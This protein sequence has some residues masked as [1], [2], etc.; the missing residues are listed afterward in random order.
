MIWDVRRCRDVIPLFRGKILIGPGLRGVRGDRA[1]AV[2]CDDHVR[3]VVRINPQIVEIAVRAVVHARHRL[4]AVGRAIGG[5]VLHVNHVH[6]LRVGK[7]VCVVERTLA[8][9]AIGIGQLPGFC[10]IV[11][12][13]ESAIL[14][15]DE[16]I[17]PIRVYRRHRHPD[18]ADHPRWHARRARDLG[19]RLTSVGGLEQSR[20][21]TTRRHGVF[22][23]ERFPHRRV[24]HVRIGAVNR[25]VNRGGLVVA[26]EHLFPG[27]ATIGAF[28]YTPVGIGYAHFSERRDKNNIGVQWMNADL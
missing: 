17:H 7:H 15:L 28:V 16:R 9:V 2:V 21:S 4:A 23:A 19:P 18:P 26:I 13:E 20:P 5:G 3:G 10:R 22:L 25:D 11:G 24:H 1:T 27:L 12:D 6:V 8:N 14:I